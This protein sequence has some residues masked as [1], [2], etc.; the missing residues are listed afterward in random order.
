MSAHKRRSN[1]VGSIACVIFALLSLAIGFFMSMQVQRMK[2]VGIHADAIVTHI[3]TGAKNSKTAIVAFK[4]E[5]NVEI[6]T[7]CIF[8]MF[9]IRHETGDKVTVLYDPS[10]PETV[11]IDN[12][13]WNWDQPVFGILGGF[14][15][16][17]LAVLILRSQPKQN[18][19]S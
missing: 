14:M 7:K 8:Q 11:M 10:E 15:L 17:G 16:L 13:I 4:T 3:R 9:V 19:A 1:I 2:S 6:E 12:G 5:D 18:I